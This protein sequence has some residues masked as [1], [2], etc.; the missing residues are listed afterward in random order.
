MKKRLLI[1]LFAMLLMAG[2][3]QVPVETVPAET[4]AVVELPD[5]RTATVQSLAETAE[6]ELEAPEV[7]E[8]SID[9]APAEPAAEPETV[10]EPA[11]PLV[12]T[13]TVPES[14]TVTADA[15]TV[16]IPCALTRSGDGPET[17]RFQVYQNGEVVWDVDLALETSQGPVR[18]TYDFTRYMTKTRDTVTFVLT[19]G[20]ETLT[21]QTAVTLENWPDEVYAEAS[22]DPLP[23]Y[24]EVVKNHNVVLVYGK[25]DDGGYTQL[26]KTFLCSTGQ[27]TPL[28]NFTAGAHYTG[29][30]TLYA[31]AEHTAYCYGQYAF[32]ISGDY[33]FH[34]VPYYSPSKDGLEYDEFNKLGTEASLGCIRLAVG[35]VKWLYD[36][37][38]VGT[39]IS[40]VEREELGVEKPDNLMLDTTSPDRG[41]DPTDPDPDNPWLSDE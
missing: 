10:E 24:V 27:W 9:P 29:F 3:G 6:E 18:L 13:L 4:T 28:G 41:W 22:G 15:P 7:P 19:Y 31:N 20:D 16:D 12:L 40:I 36:N 38:P 11:E 33:L 39:P 17:G 26:V 30:R 37:C 25:D 35:D 1:L 2:C 8:V 34:S 32:V 5:D 14:V 21:A 23:Y